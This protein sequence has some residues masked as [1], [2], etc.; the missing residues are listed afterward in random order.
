MADRSR[1]L[2][3]A[4]GALLLLV[5][6]LALLP[7]PYDPAEQVDP[8]VGRYRPPGTRLVEIHP[9]D[10]QVEDAPRLTALGELGLDRPRP[11]PVVRAA[12]PDQDDVVAVPVLREV[13]DLGR[14]PVVRGPRTQREHDLLRDEESQ[15]GGEE[16]GDGAHGWSL[17]GRGALPRPLAAAA[18]TPAWSHG[19]PPCLT[20][21]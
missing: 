21:G 15:E 3:M 4:G 18:T 17:P 11:Q 16:R 5:G 19:H 2:S 9:A 10:A 8:R 20:A 12:R 14:Q 1:I 6:T 7:T 13:L